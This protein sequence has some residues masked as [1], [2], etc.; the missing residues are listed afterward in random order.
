MRS[1]KPQSGWGKLVVQAG[2]ISGKATGF[3]KVFFGQAKQAV[4]KSVSYTSLFPSLNQHLSTA[5]YALNSSVKW[6]FI[7]TIHSTY[8]NDNEVGLLNY[9]LNT[10]EA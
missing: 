8:N 4:S 1:F 5:I 7:P 10:Q 9:Y 3:I 2:L 6:I